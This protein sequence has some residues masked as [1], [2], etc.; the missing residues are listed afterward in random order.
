MVRRFLYRPYFGSTIPDL[1]ID[2]ENFDRIPKGFCPFFC[3]K[4]RLLRNLPEDKSSYAND[5]TRIFRNIIKEKKIWKVND[6]AAEYLER[7]TLSIMIEHIYM[8]GPRFVDYYLGKKTRYGLFLYG[9]LAWPIL[10]LVFGVA[11]F[12]LPVILI[13]VLLVGIGFIFLLCQSLMDIVSLF[14]VGPSILVAFTAGVY[15]G[16][17][18]E[19]FGKK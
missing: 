7:A 5:D 10:L 18:M 6:C 12:F 17:W 8:R 11:A 13:P 9:V 3:D 2:A 19:I 16:V 15:K 1:Y 4:Q 14:I